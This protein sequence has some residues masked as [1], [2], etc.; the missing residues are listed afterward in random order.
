MDEMRLTGGNVSGPVVRVGDTVRRPPKETNTTTHRLLAHLRSRGV[1]WVPEPLG[2]DG[3]GREVL[4]FIDGEVD[5]GQTSLTRPDEVLRQVA[6]AQRQWHDASVDFPRS[7]EDMWFWPPGRDP[8]EVIAHNDFAPYNHVFRDGRLVGAID[9]DLAYPA[10]RLWDLAWTAYR[11]VPLVPG[12]DEDVLHT[13]AQ[14]RTALTPAR[15]LERLRLFLDAYG[16]VPPS[17]VAYTPDDLLAWLPERLRAIADW[18]AEQGSPDHREWGLMYAAH[19]AWW[20]S[21]GPFGGGPTQ[22]E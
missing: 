6:R 19:A 15:R 17:S 7:D 1:D 2:F 4:G 18:C 9:A 8:Q 11:Y 16:P 22:Q 14:E 5:H 12:P 13:P 21:G 20:Q 10:P 3:Q